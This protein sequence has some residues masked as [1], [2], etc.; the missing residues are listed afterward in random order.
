MHKN[1]IIG[2][3]FFFSHAEG[4]QIEGVREQDD[5]K[6]T[7][8]ITYNQLSNL[9]LRQVIKIKEGEVCGACSTHGEIDMLTNFS[10]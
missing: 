2:Y 5:K 3:D 1:T 6:N 7:C 8:K 4:K 10:S 9:Y